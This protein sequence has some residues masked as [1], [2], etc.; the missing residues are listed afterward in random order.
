MGS[1]KNGVINIVE[2]NIAKFDI[3]YRT[4]STWPGLDS[5]TVLT[6]I[7]N[8]VKNTDCLDILSGTTLTKRS[9]AETM[10]AG[11]INLWQCNIGN[12]LKK[13]EEEKEKVNKK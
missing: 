10:T 1:N 13:K 2:F 5:N 3:C 4:L 9:N 8:T 12:S 6:I 11:T 7:T